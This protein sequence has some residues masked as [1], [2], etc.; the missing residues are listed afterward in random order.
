MRPY[1]AILKRRDT[2]C[3][4]T[5]ALYLEKPGGFNFKPGQFANFTLDSVITTDPGG[6]TRTLSIASAPHEK[7]LMVAM[8]MRDTGFKRIAN[9]RSISRGRSLRQL[10]SS[11]RRRTPRCLS[12]RWH[13]HHALSEHDPACIGN[14]KRT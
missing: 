5:T 9:W 14:A 10:D 13:W 7:D 2:L 11:Q 3:D 12:C 1:T 6:I 8:R 4:G